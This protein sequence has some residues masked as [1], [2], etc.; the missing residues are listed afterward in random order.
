MI[1]ALLHDVP[2]S[3]KEICAMPTRITLATDLEPVAKDT[4]AVFDTIAQA[5][6]AELSFFSGEPT[7][8]FAKVNIPSEQVT[9]SEVGG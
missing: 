4:L 5:A 7:D 9:D 6:K 2:C 3:D 1:H 8:V